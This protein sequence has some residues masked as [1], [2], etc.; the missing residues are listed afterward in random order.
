MAPLVIATCAFLHNVCLDNGDMLEAD[1]DVA[2]DILDP[3][4]PR[5]GLA[6]D[7]SSRSATRDRLAA[8]L[9]QEAHYA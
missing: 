3:Y 1:A 2:Q 7:E 8:L 6:Q 4:A 5:E 9:T